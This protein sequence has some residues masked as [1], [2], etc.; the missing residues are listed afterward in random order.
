MDDSTTLSVAGRGGAALASKKGDQA[1]GAPRD[2]APN[3]RQ[4]HC[5]FN[6]WP[7]VERRQSDKGGWLLRRGKRRQ[8]L[9]PGDII[10]R[11]N[12]KQNQK[13]EKQSKV[14]GALENAIDDV[15]SLLHY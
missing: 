12:Q 5:Y 4:Q 10:A 11:L 1:Q 8:A 3:D 14:F 2:Q 13:A 6:P 15:P 9:Q 7:S